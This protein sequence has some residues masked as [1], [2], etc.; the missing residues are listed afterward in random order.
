M[1]MDEYD[2]ELDAVGVPTEAP[3]GKIETEKLRP[4]PKKAEVEPQRGGRTPD[5]PKT[6]CPRWMFHRKG[7]FCKTCEKVIS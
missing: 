1:T 5:R 6:Q 2:V 7:E 4:K 3:K